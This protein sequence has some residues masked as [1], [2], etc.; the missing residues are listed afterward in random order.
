MHRVNDM[1]EL[2]LAEQLFKLTETCSGNC[3]AQ[4]KSFP[5]IIKSDIGSIREDRNPLVIFAGIDFPVFLIG[6]MASS[7]AVI[8]V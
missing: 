2:V 4:W 6:Q 1:I 3:N 7:A 8:N 5:E